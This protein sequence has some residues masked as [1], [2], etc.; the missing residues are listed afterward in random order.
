MAEATSS[1]AQSPIIR[2]TS[3]AHVLSMLRARQAVK[4]ELRKHG[5]KVSHYAASEITSWALVYL[6]DHRVE[7]MPDAIETATRWMR[8]GVFGKR[9]QKAFINAHELNSR[10]S[11]ATISVA[12]ASSRLRRATN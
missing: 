9:A 8:D 2:I 4:A 12:K 7:L 3:A 6:D 11:A 5:L 1:I 10:A